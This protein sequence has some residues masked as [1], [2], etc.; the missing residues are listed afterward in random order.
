MEATPSKT[1][2]KAKTTTHLVVAIEINE[3]IKRK[4]R[5]LNNSSNNRTNKVKINN[6]RGSKTSLNKINKAKVISK[7]WIN[8]INNLRQ[9]NKVNTMEKLYSILRR[10][11]QWVKV[12]IMRMKLWMIVN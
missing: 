5:M 11:N 1:K 8:R 7:R 9:D 2:M 4:I 3:I 6:K 10:H 12:E